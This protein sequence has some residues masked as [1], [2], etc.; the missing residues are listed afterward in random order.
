[1]RGERPAQ[2]GRPLE[3]EGAI[4]RCREAAEASAAA[5]RPAMRPS[6][7]AL[8]TVA[9]AAQFHSHTTPAAY[10]PGIGSVSEP[11]EAKASL[12]A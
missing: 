5:L 11:L 9:P 12:R 7:I 3:G 8:S 2:A 1:M 4:V 6:V 10:R